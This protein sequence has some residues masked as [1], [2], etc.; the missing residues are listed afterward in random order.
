MRYTVNLPKPTDSNLGDRVS[1]H[2]HFIIILNQHKRNT[3]QCCWVAVDSSV[4]VSRTAFVVVGPMYNTF[5]GLCA[6]REF[7]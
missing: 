6:G 4:R 5:A 1:K 3:L 7:V 2:L